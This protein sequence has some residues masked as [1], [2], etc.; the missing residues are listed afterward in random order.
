MKEEYRGVW[1]F[2]EQQHAELSQASLQLLG[3]GRELADALGVELTAILL[4]KDIAAQAR[5]LIYYGADRVLSGDATVL[6][7]YRTQPYTDVVVDQVWRYKPEI[8][9]FSATS[10]GRDLA[11]RIARQLSTGCTADCIGLSIDLEK[12]LLVQT[13]PAFGDKLVA[14]IVTP[15]H[16][17]QMATVR[18]GVME[19]LPRDSTR[20]GEIMPILITIQEK[21]IITK[22]VKIVEQPREGISIEEA[23]VIVSG[24]RGL[25]G[26][27]GFKILEEVALLLGGAIGASGGAV[28][29]GWISA[30]HK[31]GQT[32]KTVKPKLY[33]ACGISGATQHLV[34]MQ[35]SKVICAINKDPKAPIFSISDYGIVGDAYQVILLLIE[36]LKY[37]KETRHA[38]EL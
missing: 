22:V 36:E 18:P 8:L 35:Q 25:G 30:D 19:A 24:G 13:K 3:K 14:T 33:F 4:G 15:D 38:S 6:E 10:L 7:N 31:I 29:A 1:V 32:G 37:L 12:R 21:D 27:E 5:E 17:P 11:P 26:A 16:R 34:G 2:I 23:E 9:L 20:V 28:D